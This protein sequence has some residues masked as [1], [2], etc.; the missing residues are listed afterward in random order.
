MARYLRDEQLSNY[1]I[2]AN[3][4]SQLV[5]VLF[6]RFVH[7]P[8]YVPNQQPLNVV[9]IMTIRFDKKGYRVFSKEDLLRYFN[10]ASSIERV[11][12]ELQSSEAI[13]SN[14]A[15]GS[16]LEVR[17][18]G[19]EQQPSHVISCSDDENWMNASFVAVGEVLQKHKNRNWL[20]RNPIVELIVQLTGLFVGFLI[21]VWGASLISPN[22]L[23]EN[24]FLISFLLVLLVSSSFWGFINLRIKSVLVGVFPHITFYRPK[25]EA[26]HRLIQVIVEGIVVAT[27]IFLLSQGFKY[28]GRVLGTFIGADA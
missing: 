19:N 10:E 13:R 21:S 8:E 17:L 14:K 24:S 25:K 20:A 7:M 1:T 6:A 22:L 11:V 3:A 28:V 15:N 5:D 2:S 26:W 4:L 12:F 23:I 16:F 18:D 9:L 27:T